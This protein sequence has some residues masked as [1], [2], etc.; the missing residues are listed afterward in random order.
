MSKPPAG[1]PPEVQAA[2]YGVPVMK[3]HVLLCAGP[4]CVGAAEGEASWAY[5]KKRIGEL[6]L[7]REPWGVFRTRC[8]CLR[9]CT[10]G[11]ILVVHPE[12]VWYRGATPAVIERVLQEH[13][14]G[15]KEV[16]EQVFA[17]RPIGGEGSCV[18]G[19]SDGGLG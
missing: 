5:L 10:D 3:K 11:P 12:G 1:T 16:F 19:C 6:G 13:L 2:A 8:H 15:G 7:D 9:I 17:R 4:D 18:S 14:L